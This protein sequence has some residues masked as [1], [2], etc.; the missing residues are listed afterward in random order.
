MS[1]LVYTKRVVE[2]IENDMRKNWL[3]FADYKA[4]LIWILWESNDLVL[5]E[6]G[7]IRFYSKCTTWYGWFWNVPWSR[8]TPLWLH[9]I[10]WYY[11]DSLPKEAILKWRIDTWKRLEYHPSYPNIYPVIISR[12]L[13]LEWLEERNSNTKKRY[14]YIHWTPNIW[15]WETD[16]LKRS[17]GCISLKP[18][19]MIDLF[20]QVKW[21]NTF[22]YI[23][24]WKPWKNLK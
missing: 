19:D 20:N 18:D 5:F 2:K 6:N 23:M 14:I 10:I 3:E 7:E 9:K 12:I 22:V 1:K 4:S 8:A 17:Y 11:W 24:N 13:Q 21:K 16:N 15:Y